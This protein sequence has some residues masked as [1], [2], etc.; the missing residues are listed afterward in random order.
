MNLNK[1]KNYLFPHFPIKILPNFKH[2]L[3]NMS[4]LYT[5]I[6]LS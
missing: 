6:F 5:L 4:F 2:K 1:L 3:I